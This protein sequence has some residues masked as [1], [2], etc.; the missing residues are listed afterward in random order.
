MQLAHE[1]NEK[2]SVRWEETYNKWKDNHEIDFK[3]C[4]LVWNGGKY[5]RMENYGSIL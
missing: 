3:S 4:V 2:Q 5:L 1:G